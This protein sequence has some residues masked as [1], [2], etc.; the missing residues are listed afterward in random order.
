MSNLDT[1]KQALL[2]EVETAKAGAEFYSRRI[3]ELE[4]MLENLKQMDFTS[5]GGTGVAEPAS[6]TKRRSAKPAGSGKE[7]LAGPGKGRGRP[8]KAQ[9]AMSGGAQSGSDADMDDTQSDAKGGAGKRTSKLPATKS[10]FWL[11]LLSEQPISNKEWLKS[12]TGALKIR[13]NPPDLQKLKQRLANFVTVATKEGTLVSE[14]TGRARRFS[15][16]SAARESAA[17]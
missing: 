11:G 13:P 16:K 17:G 12:A 8:P 3:D 10:E 6:A 15:A 4:K 9:A 1:A 5:R 2:D 7:S 14:G